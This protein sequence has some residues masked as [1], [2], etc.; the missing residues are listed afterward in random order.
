MDREFWETE[1]ET[2][3]D[4]GSL[5]VKKIGGKSL[6][7]KQRGAKSGDDALGEDE[8]LARRTIGQQNNKQIRIEP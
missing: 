2:A 7:M 6:E 4:M 3:T 1:S 8:I 5:L